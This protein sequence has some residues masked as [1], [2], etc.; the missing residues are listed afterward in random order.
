LHKYGLPYFVNNDETAGM[1][2]LLYFYGFFSYA[3]QN[4]VE[5]IY[6]G[7]INFLSTGFL[8]L[9][10]NFIS[11]NYTLANLK[12]FIYLNPDILFGLG[13]TSSIIF[14]CLSLFCFYLISKKLNLNKFYILASFLALSFSYLFIDIAIVLGKNS[15]LLLLFL[16][17]YY[18]FIKYSKKIEKFN[19]KSY[20][21]LALLGSL[22]WGINYWAATP[23]VY[24]IIYLHF[25]KYGFKKIGNILLFGLIFFIFGILLNYF[26]TGHAIL[27]LFYNPEII[28]TQ[29][30]INRFEVFLEDFLLGFK[31]IN[32][33]EKG[34]LPILFFLLLVSLFYLKTEKKKF[35][36]FNLVLIFEPI[37]LF[38]LA[39][40][41]YPQMRY[42]GP[43]LFLTYILI[44][45]F[46][47]LISI[48]NSKFGVILCILICLNY[49]Y[50]SKEKI[51]ILVNVKKIINNKFVE[52]KIFD[53]YSNKNLI[54]ISENMIYRENVKTL[55]IY[56]SLLEKKIVSLNPGSDGKNSIDEINKKIKIIKGAA[57]N[58]ILPSSKNYV[59][60]SKE[61]L[62]D[63]VDKLIN[64]FQSNFD[65]VII[66]K[67]NKDL[68][69]ILQN[70]FE[71]EKIYIAS[72]IETLRALTKYLENEFNIE[73]L[74]NITHLGSTMIV[75][76]LK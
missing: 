28:Q 58:D 8:I 36:I 66:K 12:D 4:I 13:R 50:F 48:K 75:F 49:L 37:F 44:G 61:Y 29:P 57:K 31:H 53:D 27:S 5:P 62:I 14:C 30:E 33:F 68:T 60:F 10:K 56:K 54:Y 70:R 65:Y 15:L 35:I 34:I 18:F 22:A 67:S 11:W 45:Y 74:K 20:L 3:N 52:F 39:D 25:E 40:K 24:A 69:N 42:F 1:K 21:I 6:Y 64:F 9:L 32:N 71:T 17:Q 72:G 43:S 55:E 16:T 51:S 47:N 19:L 59:F 73:R 41:I 63:D 2:N 38:A 7:F 23:S 76:K 46:I 26:V